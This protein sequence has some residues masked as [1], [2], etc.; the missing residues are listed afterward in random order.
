MTCIA[1]PRGSPRMGRAMGNGRTRQKG[2][3]FLLLLFIVAISGTSLALLGETWRSAADRERRAEIEFIL[4]AFSEALA[5]YRLATPDGMSYRP[6]QLDDLVEDQR[7]G[8]TRRHLR[9]IY[10]N[11][12]TSRIDWILRR[13]QLGI[14]AICLGSNAEM[15]AGDE[16]R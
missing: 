3:T 7:A 13:D 11:P 15:C 4:A 6:Q 14:R 9:R 10:T 2:Y 5:S 16:V 8:V 12:L 1:V